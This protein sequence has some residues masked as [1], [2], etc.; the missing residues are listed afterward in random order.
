[1][2]FLKNKSE[3]NFEAAEL[4]H[5]NY[6]YPAVVHCSYYSCVQLMKHIYLFK[7]KKTEDNLIQETRRSRDK[8]S[9][10]TLISEIHKFTEK[11]SLDKEDRF[12]FYKKIS[13]L[14]NLRNKADY[15]DIEVDIEKSKKSLDMSKTLLV[16][17]K[18][19]L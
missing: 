19:C 9:H 7:I 11:L 2:N 18:K 14:K 8:S 5:Q 6:L 17:L 12:Y 4:L 13:S 10:N 16:I 15:E 1:M 3:I